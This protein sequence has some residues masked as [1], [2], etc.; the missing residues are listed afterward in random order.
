[1]QQKVPLWLRLHA[2]G[3][4]GHAA[5]PPD[6]GG[7]VRKLVRALTAVASIE[8][9]NRLTPEVEAY[10]HQAGAPRRDERGEV[11]RGIEHELDGPRVTRLLSPSFRALLHDTVALTRLEAGTTVNSLPANAAAEVDIRLLPDEKTDAMLDRVREAAGT[12]VEVEVLVSGTPVPATSA[13]TEL[14]DRKSVV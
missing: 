3:S 4:A 10:F 2:K 8:T 13:D 11:L 14:L 5:M 7:S 1:M 12:G 9:P 6:D